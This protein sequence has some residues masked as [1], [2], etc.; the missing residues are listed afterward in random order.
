[1]DEE[2]NPFKIDRPNIVPLVPDL[3]S[4]ILSAERE[5]SNIISNPWETSD[6]EDILKSINDIKKNNKPSSP[7]I[8]DSVNPKLKDNNNFDKITSSSNFRVNDPWA[9]PLVSNSSNDTE[10]NKNDIDKNN[11]DI[12]YN[13]F[14]S[15][16]INTDDLDAEN[17]EDNKID[18]KNK[19]NI[20][21]SKM[22]ASQTSNISQFS[23]NSPINY[24]DN[25]Q[26]FIPTTN[27]LNS[28]EES[29]VITVRISP[30]K[31]GIV[32]KHVN[33]L[34]HSKF[35]KLAST[36]RYSDFLWLYEILCKRYQFRIM[37]SL[38]PKHM[39]TN[40]IPSS[41]DLAFLEKRR[42]GLS[43]FMNY[44]GN[45]PV[46]KND[47]FFKKFLN[48]DVNISQ[49]RKSNSNIEVTEEFDDTF[50][51]PEQRN[52]IPN[53]FEKKLQNL[54]SGLNFLIEQ[55]QALFVSMETISKNIESSSNE[56]TN[57]GYSLGQMSEFKD[58][59]GLDS[60]N[61]KLLYNGYAHLADGFQKIS[62]ILHE[63]F[64][65]T[66]NGIVDNLQTQKEILDGFNN[67]LQVRDYMINKINNNLEQII[68]RIS[69]N[70]KKLID[71]PV[72]DK[73][74]ERLEFQVTQ[75]QKD[76]SSLE[77]K[78]EFIKYCIFSEATFL[79]SQKM[80]IADMYS[81]YIQF[82]VRITSTLHDQ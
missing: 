65:N 39:G 14:A 40:M 3:N 48:K 51:T 1:M 6:G 24:T 69:I 73:E 67:L 64:Q 44:I 75:D 82:Q 76:Q 57:I 70:T 77:K 10:K 12:D 63:N 42:R 36:R 31:S 9:A 80:K 59:L 34:I 49:L 7:P 61:F 33:Y 17:S 11:N 71:T 18:I 72:K 52:M 68:K 2:D 53:D 62:S 58:F 19:S 78:I 32:F 37:I 41:N 20:K 79:E 55:Y 25:S 43:R 50:L 45:H 30:E 16:N 38:P 66:L 21:N 15:L 28:S 22:R 27:F 54:R 13:K 60:N 74:K 4:S 46:M 81:E 23:V 5:K 47:E 8:K 29:D 35:H 26:S 56:F